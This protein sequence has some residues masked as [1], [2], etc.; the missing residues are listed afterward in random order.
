[1]TVAV[2]NRSENIAQVSWEGA[3]KTFVYHD[4]EMTQATLVEILPT[5]SVKQNVC[6]IPT[7]KVKKYFAG[8]L[9]EFVKFIQVSL[10]CIPPD[11]ITIVKMWNNKRFIQHIKSG[12][13]KD[14]SCPSE[15]TDTFVDCAYQFLGIDTPGQ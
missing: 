5:K 1:M 7:R 4:I 13:G 14:V 2:R 12:L 15:Y 8:S 3:C 10:A 9:L 11:N 6:W